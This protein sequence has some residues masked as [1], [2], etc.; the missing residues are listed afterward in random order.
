ME[1]GNM[2]KWLLFFL[3][4]P[5][6]QGCLGGAQK[7][8]IYPVALPEQ[9]ATPT[10]ALKITGSLL[11][12]VEDEM[13]QKLVREAVANNPDLRAT[14]LRLKS[15][16]LLLARTGRARLPQLNGG[17]TGT[18]RNPGVEAD[19]AG[20]HRLSLALSWE[21][22]LWGRLS[23]AHH[24]A[25]A[26]FRAGELDWERALDSLGARVLQTYFRVKG[27]QLRLKA[28]E[29]RVAIFK[30]IEQT[31]LERYRAGLGRLDDLSSARSRTETA[32]A[33]RAQA[34]EERDR[35]LRDLEVLLG[36]YPGLGL[37]LKPAGDLPRVALPA[38][39]APAGILSHRPDV[40]AAWARVQSADH[41]ASA[42]KKARLPGITL[43]GNIFR[44]NAQ[45]AKLGAASTVWNLSGGLLLPLFDGGRL[46]AESRAANARAQAAYMDYTSVV[47]GAMKEAEN[48]FAREAALA[49]RQ[50]HLE[51]ALVQAGLSSRYYESA[52]GE[53][54]SDILALNTAREQELSLVFSLIDLRVA[55]LV[56]RVDMA[57]ALGTCATLRNEI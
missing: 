47:L 8:A 41:G 11:E 37:A 44:D 12:M 22:D 31:V 35:S 53:G 34:R 15:A 28:Q 55:R 56:N 23:D 2:K 16:G 5:L 10:P 6:V 9:L 14:A 33:Q 26:E 20:E 49:E 24:A 54:V 1:G 39:M 36:R 13:A 46:R 45:F 48:T 51:Q 18:R 7:R 50:T 52:Y 3:V 29:D 57:L 38:A 4:L 17:Y 19:S 32:R 21:L 30:N 27:N 43:T 25:R 42:Q 40:Q